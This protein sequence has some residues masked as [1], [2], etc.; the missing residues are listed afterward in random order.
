NIYQPRLNI[1]G[2]VISTRLN[3]S[4]EHQGAVADSRPRA[5]GGYAN[6]H[7]YVQPNIDIPLGAACLD[8]PMNRRRAFLVVAHGI[9]LAALASLSL[10]NSFIGHMTPDI[11]VYLLQARSFV[12]TLN[13]GF[14]WENKGVMLTFF[15]AVP[16]RA[17]GPTMAAAA[18]AQLYA[19]VRGILL[20]HF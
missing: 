8:H 15:L 16:V 19:Y 20:F 17:F 14:S 10:V 2:E 3:I 7:A 18:L 9:P 12:E 1:S 13:R 6:L 5:T 4:G 11:S